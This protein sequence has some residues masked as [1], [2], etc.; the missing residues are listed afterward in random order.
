MV[1]VDL[2]AKFRRALLIAGLVIALLVG[3]IV[4]IVVVARHRRHE[5]Q[6]PPANITAPR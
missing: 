5:L 2:E 1:F 4:A 3:L 6:Q